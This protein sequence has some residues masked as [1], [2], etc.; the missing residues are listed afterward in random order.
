MP[1]NPVSDI[2]G[3]NTLE[4]KGPIMCKELSALEGVHSI[5]ILLYI[6]KHEG[7]KKTDIY[8]GLARSTS[9]QARMESMLSADLIRIERRPGTRAN[10]LYLTDTGR[11]LAT[12]L[13][14]FNDLR[15]EESEEP[16]ARYVLD[17]FEITNLVPLDRD[18][19]RPTNL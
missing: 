18:Y 15:E 16:S 17:R 10:Y 5:E 3:P 19:R 11:E 1:D 7:C 6:L 14:G 4:R 13:E 2:L 12:I 8:N 9:V